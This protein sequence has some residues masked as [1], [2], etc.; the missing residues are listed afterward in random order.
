VPL[1]PNLEQTFYLFVR[2]PKDETVTVALRPTGSDEEVCRSQPLALKAN[3][4]KLVV[5]E[6]PAPVVPPP[7]APPAAPAAAPATPPGQEI[8]AP[9][10]DYEFVMLDAANKVVGDRRLLKLLTP[11]EYVANPTVQYVAD[12]HQLRVEV[13]AKADFTGPP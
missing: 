7:A 3:Q 8:K 4:P 9:P 1:R 10:F 5:F 6:T 2:S 13:T 11:T 12:N